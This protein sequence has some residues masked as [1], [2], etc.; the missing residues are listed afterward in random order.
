MHKEYMA[1]GCPSSDFPLTVF[2]TRALSEGLK[3]V[4]EGVTGACARA[5]KTSGL[6]GAVQF[7][8]SALSSDSVRFARNHDTVMNPNLYYGLGGGRDAAALQWAWLLSLHDGSVLVFPE[9]FQ[10]Q[11]SSS[12]ICRALRFRQ[13]M[14]LATATE[15]VLR[16]EKATAPPVLL[17]LALRD[18][19]KLLGMALLNLCREAVKVPSALPLPSLTRLVPLGG[20]DEVEVQ[21]DGRFTQPLLLAA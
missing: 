6:K 15:V 7:P 1:L 3:A 12:L 19:E 10:Q 4:E 5:A 17:L 18:G 16:Y 21:T 11:V 8:S 9:D 20:T 2:M 14:E 13:Q